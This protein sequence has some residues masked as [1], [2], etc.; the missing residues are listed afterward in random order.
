MPLYTETKTLLACFRLNLLP[1]KFL[2]LVMP[3]GFYQNFTKLLFTNIRM[4]KKH[5]WCWSSFQFPLAPSRL[6]GEWQSP[7][8]FHNSRPPSSLYPRKTI[9]LAQIIQHNQQSFSGYLL[10]H[11]TMEMSWVQAPF[12]SLEDHMDPEITMFPIWKLLSRMH[13]SLTLHNTESFVIGYVCAQYRTDMSS[14]KP[15]N[16]RTEGIFTL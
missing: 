16:L 9:R 2:V 5:T 3:S 15:P 1:R 8:P 11:A 6:Q 13:V 12:F 10:K 14:L 4:H 7:R